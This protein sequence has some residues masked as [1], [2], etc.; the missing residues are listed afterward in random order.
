MKII[1]F[2]VLLSA[3]FQFSY[4]QN[5]AITQKA[6]I[7]FDG[8]YECKEWKF[9]DDRIENPSPAYYRFFAGNVLLLAYYKDV[10]DKDTTAGPQEVFRNVLSENTLGIIKENMEEDSTNVYKTVGKFKVTAY[11]YEKIKGGICFDI[12]SERTNCLGKPN[13]KLL[14]P[15]VIKTDNGDP[16]DDRYFKFIP[17]Y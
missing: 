15:G 17:S 11:K 9:V 10:K 2:T 13:M 8:I 5:S 7:R 3:F 12:L 16:A 6:D 4:A 14:S 1:F